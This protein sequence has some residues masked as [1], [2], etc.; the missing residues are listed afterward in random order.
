MSEPE[1]IVLVVDDERFFREAICDALRDAGLAC[2]AVASASS[3]FLRASASVSAVA[4]IRSRSPSRKA[5][6]A[7]WIDRKST[8]LNSSH[9]G[10]SRMPSSA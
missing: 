7:S 6:S 9:N 10:Q 2:R 3:S 8:R 5:R 1:P 4:A